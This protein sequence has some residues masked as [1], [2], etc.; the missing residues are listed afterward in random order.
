M[1]KESKVIGAIEQDYFK[2]MARFKAHPGR[3]AI[4]V[5]YIQGMSDA[6]KSVCDL[7]DLDW[8]ED[9]CESL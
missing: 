2:Q 6:Y 7:I 5:A 9:E 4:T 3:D 8:G 1:T